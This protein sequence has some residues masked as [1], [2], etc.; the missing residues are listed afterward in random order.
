MLQSH[1]GRE[2]DMSGNRF[3]TPRLPYHPSFINALHELDAEIG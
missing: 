3:T 2:M 1:S